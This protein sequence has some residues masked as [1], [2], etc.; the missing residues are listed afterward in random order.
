VLQRRSA[1]PSR[2]AVTA[3]VMWVVVG[4]TCTAPNPAYDPI[5]AAADA[6]GGDARP[7]DAPPTDNLPRDTLSLPPEGAGADAGPAPPRDAA[8]VM[9]A[10]PADPDL[11]LCLRFENA[12]RDE[13]P[14]KLAMTTNMV[15]YEAGPDGMAASLTSESRIQA[16]DA[17]TLANPT[18]TIE[19]LIKPRAL[20][21]SGER[22]VLVDYSR[23]YALVLLPGGTLRCRLNTGGSSF[24]ELNASATIKVGVWTMV[25]CVVSGASVR[26][27]HGGAEQGS[28]GLDG[29]LVARNSTE[30]FLVGRNHPT[31]A[32][33]EADAFLGAIDNVRIWRHARTTAQLCQA[34]PACATP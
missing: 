8:V 28:A 24:E 10:C 15:S 31:S 27:W 13:S 1:E 9:T 2:V 7:G 23:Q 22:A 33:P 5:G 34:D 18:I 20:P 26:L 21:A 25:A 17:P 6:G 32:N 29:P 12:V 11:S 4:A 14:G 30:P 3:G 16:A 19:A